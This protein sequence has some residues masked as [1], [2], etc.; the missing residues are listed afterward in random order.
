M[1]YFA[2]PDWRHEYGGGTEFYRATSSSSRSNWG[3]RRV[4]FS[5]VSTFRTAEFAPNRLVMFV[6]SWDSFHG[7]RPITCPTTARRKSVNFNVLIA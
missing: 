2:G 6:K 4:E 3:N 5:D 1:L 7:V